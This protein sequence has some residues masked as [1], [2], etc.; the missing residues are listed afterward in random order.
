MAGVETNYK[1]DVL[2]RLNEQT[3][4]Q[5]LDR[6]YAKAIILSDRTLDA[7]KNICKKTG[8]NKREKAWKTDYQKAFQ[9]YF[10]MGNNRKLH[11][12]RVRRRL[13]K[14]NKR[15]KRGIKINIRSNTGK[16]SKRCKENNTIAGFN[17]TG[18]VGRRRFNICERALTGSAN[19][20]IDAV[21]IMHE[22]MHSMGLWGVTTDQV[23]IN[24]NVVISNAAALQLAV[25]KPRRA[26][27]N[28]E[29]YEQ[30][31]LFFSNNSL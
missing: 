19:V 1:G 30:L 11:I 10:G 18:P 2:K 23:D 27:R 6:A 4:D 29:N 9:L 14:L 8:I 28:P 22:L 5:R 24:D 31:F 26:R 16:G 12:R 13:N 21:L 17:M 25:D 15:L 7:I 3:T 20:D